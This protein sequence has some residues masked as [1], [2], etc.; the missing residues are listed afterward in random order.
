VKKKLTQQQI[1]F[2]QDV[3]RDIIPSQSYLIHYKCKPSAAR[4][5]ASRLLTKANIQA[6]LQELRDKAEDDLISTEKER[7][8]RL[9]LIE[10]ATLGDFVDEHGNLSITDKEQLRTPAVAEIRTERTGRG[11]IRTTLKLRDPISA[12]AEHNKMD[13]VYSD[14]PS[15][16]TY[17][18]QINF[19]VAG[20]AAKNLVDGVAKRLGN[21]SI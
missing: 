5:L 10:R 3:F 13:K 12:I 11:G 16:N 19:I 7:R 20:E 1:N 6:Y 15:G 4:S 8:E 18:Q 17:N 21:E 14:S 9:T 2:V